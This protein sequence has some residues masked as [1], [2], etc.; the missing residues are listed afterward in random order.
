MSK[1]DVMQI[2]DQWT[3]SKSKLALMSAISQ[4]EAEWLFLKG[5]LPEA[6][7]DKDAK[8][9]QRFIMDEIFKEMNEVIEG[10]ELR[11]ID[12]ANP[13]DSAANG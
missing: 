2:S 11:A 8:W 6:L 4:L 13:T 3:I 9:G 1:P 10:P 7:E 5:H 12:S